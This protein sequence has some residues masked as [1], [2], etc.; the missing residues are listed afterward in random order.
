MPIVVTQ[1]VGYIIME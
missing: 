1:G